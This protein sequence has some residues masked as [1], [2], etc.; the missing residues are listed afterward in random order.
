MSELNS[1]KY[2]HRDIKPENILIKN[3]ICVLADMGLCCR[4]N[5]PDQLHKGKCGTPLYMSP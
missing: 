3:G 5:K 2:M 4:F 1:L